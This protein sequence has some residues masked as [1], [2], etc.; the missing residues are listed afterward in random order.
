M[1]ILKRPRV[2]IFIAIISIMLYGI[3]VQPMA[4]Y[5]AGKE[6]ADLQEQL[7]NEVDIQLDKLDLSALESMVDSVIQSN[8]P[9]ICL[10][11]ISS[12]IHSVIQG[13]SVL[14]YESVLGSIFSSLT[15]CVQKYLPLIL[16]VVAVAILCSLLGRL[17]G[18][19]GEKSVSQITNFIFVAV[20]IVALGSCI[21]NLV[22][23]TTNTMSSI[24]TQM[25][26]VFPILLTL[27]ASIGSI[28][29]VGLYQPTMA[30]LTTGISEIFVGFV[31]PIFVLAIVFNFVG[32]MTQSV[33]LD[34]I[35]AFLNSLFKWV[36]GISFTIFFATIAIQG[37]CVN[38]FDGISIRTAKFTLK[39]YIPIM[40]GYLS[41]GFDIILS[42][43]LLIKN[44]IGVVGMIVLLSSVLNP[45]LEI[46]IF[47]LLL[48][49]CCAVVQP[50]ADE[51]IVK[52][53]EGTSKSLQ[54]LNTI[55]IVVSF[56]YLIM[57][58][59]V[60]STASGLI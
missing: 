49:L 16:F 20:I 14:N 41:D 17:K 46:V 6:M 13:D 33:K 22:V 3:Y 23:T 57:I 4:A 31:L 52:M 27:T 43:S 7:S 42:S 40:G 18:K 59:M 51:H 56:M 9:I 10:D 47:S 44:G 5:A 12:T 38:S 15:G 34:K 35:V 50:F 26:A 24:R 53:V 58:G 37:L 1:K 8:K 60:M 19:F 11:N 45:I 2:V 39:S 36:V 54:I 55:I 30:I 28:K 25:G 48:K 32:N 21:K 29:S